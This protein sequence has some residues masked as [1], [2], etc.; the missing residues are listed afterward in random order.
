MPIGNAK[1]LAFRALALSQ[2]TLSNQLSN[3]NFC[4]S[5]RHRRSTTVF[6]K[7]IYLAELVHFRGK[8]E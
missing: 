1:K 7:F 2:F 3:S 6:L 5:L 4:V 8:N